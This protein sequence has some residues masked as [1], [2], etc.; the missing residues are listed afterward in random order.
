M[1][2]ITHRQPTALDLCA[3]DD[4]A[5]NRSGRIGHLGD[6]L[7]SVPGDLAGIAHLA[8]GLPVERGPIENQFDGLARA[9]LADLVCTVA[10][11]R[12]QRS[13]S[14]VPLALVAEEFRFA[15]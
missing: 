2:D 8:T 6:R 1:T 4:Q 13:F 14:L 5:W 7:A 11:D 10:D 12:H 15:Q 3:M 9:C